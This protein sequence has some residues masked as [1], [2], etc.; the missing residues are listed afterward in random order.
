MEALETKRTL[1][2]IY[3]SQIDSQIEQIN[4]KIK[5]F[6]QH[7]VNYQQNNWTEQLF[8]VEFQYNNKRYIATSYTLFKL[9]FERYLWKEDLTIKMELPK[10]EN[11]LEGLQRSW[12]AVKQ[13][14]E[15]VQ[16]P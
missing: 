16:K 7:Y 13:S 2:T 12:E 9:N 6:L 1:S 11:F 8:T 4:Q 5:A 3:H 10:L 15:I 14:I